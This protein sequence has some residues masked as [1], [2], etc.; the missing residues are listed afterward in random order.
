[1]LLHSAGC[2][3]NGPVYWSSSPQDHII[4]L[5]SVPFL[6]YYSCPTFSKSQMRS[7]ALMLT[8]VCH[9]LTNSSAC[10]AVKSPGEIGPK[11]K[12]AHMMAQQDLLSLV[13][14]LHPS[15]KAQ[16]P[17]HSKKGPSMRCRS[18]MTPSLKHSSKRQL[19]LCKRLRVTGNAE[20]ACCLSQSSLSVDMSVYKVIISH[21]A[22][23]TADMC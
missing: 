1:M 4:P 7:L 14:Q 18:K 10:D 19:S 20:A 17:P 21:H 3:S 15:L 11:S 23:G 16:Q 13:W 22:F 12:R 9:G 8:I 5:R 2:T 6:A